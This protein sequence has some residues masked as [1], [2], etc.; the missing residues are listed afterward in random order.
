MDKDEPELMAGSG[1]RQ[2]EGPAEEPM[3]GNGHEGRLLAEQSFE[4]HS[5][6]GSSRQSAGTGCTGDGAG[7]PKSPKSGSTADGEAS[8]S[9]TAFIIVQGDPFELHKVVEPARS[10]AANVYVILPYRDIPAAEPVDHFGRTHVRADEP[11]EGAEKYWQEPTEQQPD[12]GHFQVS[13][14]QVHL[15][16]SY[17]PGGGI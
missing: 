6:A 5:M 3:H 9:P 14:G 4:P 11:K 12:D 7:R 10:S 1:N 17:A 8:S 2:C 16:P 15:S 13:Q